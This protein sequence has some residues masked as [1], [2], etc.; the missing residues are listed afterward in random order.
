MIKD[1]WFDYKGNKFPV[2]D[3]VYY[4]LLLYDGVYR[5]I[6]IDNETSGFCHYRDKFPYQ[7]LSGLVQIVDQPQAPIQTFT[8]HVARA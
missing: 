5:N 8:R 3:T 6:Y 4:C 1:F 7:R 2:N